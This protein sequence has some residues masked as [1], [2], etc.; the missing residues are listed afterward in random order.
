MTDA[1]LSDRQGYYLE[2]LA[3]GME[4]EVSKQL[5]ET[6]V[7]MF[8]AVS[9]DTNPIH[10]DEAFAAQSRFGTRIVHG[11]L[12][13][14]LW[15]AL[16]GTRLPGPG[17]IYLKQD[18]TFRNPVRIDETV[19]ARVTITEIDDSRQRVSFDT[20]CRVGDLDVATGRAVVWVPRR[21]AA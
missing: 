16:L 9:E 3:V 4:A 21:E 6:E 17:A 8:A 15:S 19:T 13:V 10:L 20:V 5:T 7:A 2:D 18:I 12:T 14:S 1:N 11:M